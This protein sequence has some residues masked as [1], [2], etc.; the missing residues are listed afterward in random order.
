MSGIRFNHSTKEIE[1]AASKSFIAAYFNKV[2]DLLVE[3]FGE[4][5]KMAVSR[6]TNMNQKP[7]S[8][9]KSQEAPLNAGAKRHELSGVS[10]GSPPAA[11]AI[12]GIPFALE[13]NRPPLRKYIRKE[14][15]PGNQ[16]IVVQVAEQ[17]PKEISLASVKEKFGLAES[18]VGETIRDAEKLGR[19]RR[20]M[21]ASYP[22]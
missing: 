3:R 1:M 7:A 18:K 17:K 20:A 14:G 4:K 11:S 6:I 9:G 12:P 21:N 2:Q 16:R 10:L 5:T 19:I 22:Y 13:A 8:G 15:I